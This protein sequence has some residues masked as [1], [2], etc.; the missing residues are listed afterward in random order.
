MFC[1]FSKC[2]IFWGLI[3]WLQTCV[4]VFQGPVDDWLQK[5]G[6][7]I[8]CLRAYLIFIPAVLHFDLIGISCA[9]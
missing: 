8:G 2:H 3:F 1:L 7:S 6:V 5:I 4:H 9:G